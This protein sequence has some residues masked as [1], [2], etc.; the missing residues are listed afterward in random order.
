[1]ARPRVF[2]PQRRRAAPALHRPRHRPQT[3]G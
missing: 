2:G 1:M 3:C